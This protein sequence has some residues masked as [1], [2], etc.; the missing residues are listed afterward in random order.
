MKCLSL[1]E[2][3]VL[4]ESLAVEH[5]GLFTIVLNNNNNNNKSFF[6]L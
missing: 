4:S 3:K 1:M 5:N 6:H 2:A